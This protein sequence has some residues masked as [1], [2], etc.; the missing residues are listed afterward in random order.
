MIPYSSAKMMC[1]Q[2]REYHSALA[3]EDTGGHAGASTV[4]CIP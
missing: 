1:D 3:R 2:K 4:A